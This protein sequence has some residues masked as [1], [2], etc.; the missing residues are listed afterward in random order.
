MTL[1][2]SE[3][4]N[5]NYLAKVV[6]LKN[7]RKHHNADKLQITTIDGN[8]VILGLEAKEGDLY[9][10]FPLE[11]SI[12]SDF[13]AYSNS[14]K[15]S[16]LNKNQEVS[17]FFEYHGR[18][19]ALSL[20]GEKSC[21]YVC[22][23][24]IINEWLSGLEKDLT[25]T[26]DD[27]DTEFDSIC[28]II[29]CEKYINREALR[30]LK[31]QNTN[32]GQSK[33]ERVSRLIEG[34]FAFHVDTQHLQKFIR[35]ISPED[36]IHISRKL[37]GTSGIA[38][39]ILCLR[40]LSLKEN[41][42][43]SLGIKVQETEYELIWSSRKVVKNKN[44]YLNWLETLQV[45]ALNYIKHPNNFISD[46]SLA[47]KKPK[48]TIKNLNEWYSL[49]N[50]P[51]K[52]NHYYSH[53]IWYDAAIHFEPFLSEGLTFYF[54]IVGYTKDGGYLQKGYD[55]GCAVGEFATYIYRITYTNPTGKVFEFSTQQ[56][57]DYC[58]RYGLKMVPEIYWG[59][60]KDLFEIPVDDSWHDNF[61]QAISDAYLEQDC[62]L[63]VNKVPDEGIVLRKE[64]SD[65]EPYKYKSFAFWL[66]ETKQNDKGVIDLETLESEDSDD[67]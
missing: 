15:D 39:K 13:L 57:K 31:K 36:V 21:G 51:P 12:N 52:S 28:G 64:V 30:R 55:Y 61:L 32:K 42:A 50:N 40:K 11:C 16:T 66:R 44:F 1:K 10:Y 27:V 7:I 67:L 4:A 53:D 62:E 2:I 22:P 6:K 14:F 25:I 20:R 58:E 5:T 8:N 54:E 63:C 49:I 9:V 23:I 33:L 35:K 18:V 17:G 45:R 41:I 26:E 37:H 48:A 56:I 24:H 38:G 3:K 60:A 65:I 43:R 34:Q 19:K 46:V 59:I 29:L 47:I